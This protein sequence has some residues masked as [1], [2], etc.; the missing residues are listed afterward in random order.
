MLQCRKTCAGIVTSVMLRK[1]GWKESQRLRRE[2]L[3]YD[4]RNSDSGRFLVQDDQD[5]R[6]TK[7]F[8]GDESAVHNYTEGIKEGRGRFKGQIWDTHW[9]G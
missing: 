5:S 2:M 1:H 3:Y 7:M 6:E 4:G 9:P 8:R